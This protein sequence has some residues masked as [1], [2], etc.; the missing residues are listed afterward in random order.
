VDVAISPDGKFLT[1]AARGDSLIRLWNID[2]G[3]QILALKHD[4]SVAA[5]AFNK[6]G[7]K[8]GSGSYDGTARLWELPSGREVERSP[9][10][11]GS[12]VVTF[13][14]DGKRFA[15]GGMDGAVS[16]SESSRTD[17]PFSFELPGAV[18]SVAFSPDGRRFAIGAIS[19][20]HFPVVRVAQIDG[21]IL[22]DIELKDSTVV[23][24]L[25]FIDSNEIIAQWGNRL[26]SIGVEHSS[27]THLPD[28]PGEKRV[29][30]SGKV[31]AVQRDGLIRIYALP[32]FQQIASLNDP[33]SDDRRSNLLRTVGEGKLLAF[34]ARKPPREFAVD[35]WSVADKTWVSHVALPADLTRVAVDSTGNVLFTAQHENLQAWEIP[36]GKQ[37]FQITESGDIDRI[38][39]DPSSAAFAI[40]SGGRLSVWDAHTGARLSQLPGATFHTAAFSPDGRWL[41]AGYDDHSAALWLWRTKDLQ[42]RACTRLTRN[43]SHEEWSRWFPKQTYHQTCPN[44]PVVR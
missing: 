22:G 32:D 2:T 37:R 12:E 29:D 42:D 17:R 35:L 25:F 16:V 20:R 3:R 38:I 13:S 30:P 41:I 8:L 23:D 28:L 5:V 10:G 33:V 18:R 24:S 9:H 6:D 27:A 34:E 31:F 21:K 44:L 1:Y 14:P 36:S 4:N 19:A 11:Q 43:F 7:T 26:F 40:L 39:P 15:A